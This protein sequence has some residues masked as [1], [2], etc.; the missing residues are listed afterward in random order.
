MLSTRGGSMHLDWKMFSYGRW[1]RRANADN[2][3]QMSRVGGNKARGDG[4]GPRIR[5]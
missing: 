1:S 2:T 5:G 4:G 3:R